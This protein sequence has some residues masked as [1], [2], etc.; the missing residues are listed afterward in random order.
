[1]ISGPKSGCRQNCS[2]IGRY[3]PQKLLVSGSAAG[4]VVVR[5][6]RQVA[7][8]GAGLGGCVVRRLGKYLKCDS[9]FNA[10][11]A[12]SNNIQPLGR[13]LGRRWVER[14]VICWEYYWVRRLG[15]WNVPMNMCFKF[16]C[17]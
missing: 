2:E 13:L 14:W 7:G 11:R 1:M 17:R 9:N 15:I 12:D 6:G 4:Q 3:P 8:L 16:Q 5:A 10:A